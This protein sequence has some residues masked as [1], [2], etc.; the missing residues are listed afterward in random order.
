MQ[1][2]EQIGLVAGVLDLSYDDAQLLFQVKLANAY[3]PVPRLTGTGRNIIMIATGP[4]RS[5][6]T[7]LMYSKK[8][9]A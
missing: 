3:E 8:L 6:W 1:T 2:E 9:S 5:T 7:I 4:S